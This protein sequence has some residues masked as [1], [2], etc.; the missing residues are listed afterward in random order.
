MR[1]EY[2]G[3]APWERW[4]LYFMAASAIFMIVTVPWT[5]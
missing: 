3:M 1:R 4:L 2:I 5:R